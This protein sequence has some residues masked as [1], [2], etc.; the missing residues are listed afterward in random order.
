MDGR[1][2][3]NLRQIIAQCH[4]VYNHV[5]ASII[6]DCVLSSIYV[7]ICI[8]HIFYYIISSLDSNFLTIKSICPERCEEKPDKSIES[9]YGFFF[10]L[11]EFRKCTH[12]DVKPH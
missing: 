7:F 2:Y 6:I 9:G 4:T 5:F 10:I 1:Y 12:V 8:Y 11:F 3:E